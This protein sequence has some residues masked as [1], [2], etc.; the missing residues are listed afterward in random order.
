MEWEV[1]VSS[2][3]KGR[4]NEMVYNVKARGF[5]ILAVSL[6]PPNDKGNAIL[7]LNGSM[8]FHKP[9][10]SKAVPITQRQKLLGNAAYGDIAAT[11][12]AN[13]YKAL[14]LGEETEGD[15][16][17]YVYDLKAI[18]KKAT[19]DGIKYWVSQQRLVG[20]KAEYFTVSG[21]PFKTATMEY[22]NNIQTEGKAR[23]FISKMHIRDVLLTTDHTILTFNKANMREIPDHIF[24]LNLLVK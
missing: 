21:K 1:T 6:S 15:E 17:C 20:I 5:D 2:V 22:E 9:G 16:V 8:W 3:E 4:Q 12:Y 14:L 10:L 11:N 19:Y 23:P 18:E 24:N 7:M 13:E